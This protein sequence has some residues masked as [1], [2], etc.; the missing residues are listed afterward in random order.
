MTR[1]L[2]ANQVC[3]DFGIPT[4]STLR[5]MR[6][7]GLPHVRLGK[8]YLYDPQDVA[9]F[10]ESAKRCHDRTQAPDCTGRRPE[11]RSTSS[12][13]SMASNGFER[14]AQQTAASLKRLSRTS[15]AQVIDLQPSAAR[16]Q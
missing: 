14:Q 6:A 16:R 4:P 3:A 2:T 5:T 11:D 10:I 1:L 8:Q 15:S 7:N 13:T 12:G 9:A